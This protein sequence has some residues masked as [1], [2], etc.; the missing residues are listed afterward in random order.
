MR[1]DFPGLPGPRRSERKQAKNFTPTRRLI[2]CPRARP[3]S[4]GGT[5]RWVS[6]RNSAL[7]ANDPINRGS[8]HRDVLKHAATQRD[9]VLSWVCSRACTALAR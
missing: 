4:L 6:T 3:P 7:G 9:H 2:A 1:N 5:R 8:E